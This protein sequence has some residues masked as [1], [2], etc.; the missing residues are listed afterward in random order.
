MDV[1]KLYKNLHS[2]VPISL[3]NFERLV[4]YFQPLAV[5]KK[6]ILIEEGDFNIRLFFVE[7][8]LL[9]L[10]KTLEDGDVQ[11]IQFAKENYWISDLCSFFTGSRALFA[12]QALEDSTL[13]T[14]SKAHFDELCLNYPGMETF[15]RL[16]FQTAY[17]TTLM[18]LSDAYSQDAEAKYKKI[19]DQQP[20][21]LQR[22]PQYLIA[23]YLGVL[24]S[25][26]SRIRSK[27]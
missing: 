21:L 17:V 9:Y 1:D 13:W 2:R 20:D 14:L 16:S 7:R 24:P 19:Q 10:Y 11:V 25:S 15:F 4:P 18:R 6:T 8:G 22:V 23:S 26:L 5:K 27:K 12:I 3:E